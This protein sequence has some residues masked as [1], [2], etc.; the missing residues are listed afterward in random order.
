[1]IEV[2]DK[3]SGDLLGSI[4]DEQLKFLIDQLEEESDTDQDY[5]LNGPTLEMFEEKGAD[6]ELMAFL[7]KVLGDRE[8]AEIVWSRS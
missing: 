6:P 2:R 1:M 4:T 3:A 8:E 7:R 5:Y